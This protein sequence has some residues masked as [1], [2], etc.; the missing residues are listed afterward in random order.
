MIGKRARALGGAGLALVGATV[1]ALSLYDVYED[2][3]VQNDPLSLTVLENAVPFGL[4]VAV[5]AVGVAVTTGRWDR[6]GD[7]TAVAK[8]GLA[9][10]AG[11]AVVAAWTYGFQQLQGTIKPGFLA[12]YM[13]I[14]GAGAGIVIGVYD[15]VQSERKRDLSAQRAT[16]AHHDR[17]HIAFR[18][19]TMDLVA[20]DSREEIETTTCEAAVSGLPFR[21]AWIGGQH[22]G[23]G[24]V[25][26]RCRVS[27]DAGLD[28]GDEPGVE[29]AAAAIETGEPQTARA[30]GRDVVAVPVAYAGTSYGALTVATR[31][32]HEVRPVERSTLAEMGEIA[33]YAI[34]ATKTRRAMADDD[35][36][37]V[38]FEV[39]APDCALAEAATAVAGRVTQRGTVAA[40][41]AILGVFAVEDG[42]PGTLVAAAEGCDAV[43][44]AETIREDGD[45]LVELRFA[46]ESFYEISAGYGGVVREAVATGDGSWFRVELPRDTE[47]R[48]FVEAVRAEYP[49]AELVARRDV[50]RADRGERTRDPADDLLTER[51][52][53]AL[54]MALL[55]GYYESPRERTGEE[56]AAA[57]GVSGP[58]FHKHLRVGHRKL[59]STYLDVRWRASDS[60]V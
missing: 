51:Q 34:H 24:S 29:A 48:S 9:G 26:P 4:S 19:L 2:F 33:G 39:S 42:D 13:L 44:R 22:P 20:A 60:A 38:E 16:L 49:T 31:R 47:V 6:S 41:G 18:D 8:W 45:P 14:W 32:S 56:I 11:I 7:G 55:S 58:T 1:M 25:D 37:E 21:V 36:T 35:A 3:L 57:L 30:D 28:R 53:T 52:A 15:A 17:A 12:G 27:V 43:D 23:D 10:T 40:D 50:T 54:K 46:D 59:A 5:V